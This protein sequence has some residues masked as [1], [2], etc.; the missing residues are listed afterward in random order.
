M[1]FTVPSKAFLS[2][3]SPLTLSYIRYDWNNFLKL[4]FPRHKLASDSEAHRYNR[5]TP[6]IY[7]K[8]GKSVAIARAGVWADM[9]LVENIDAFKRSI[10]CERNARNENRL[11][12]F[13]QPDLV[14][15]FLVAGT[16]IRHIV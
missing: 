2:V 12:W 5:T 4:K 9:A 10:M 14:N 3:N 7:P 6:I 13:M 11:D 15:Q 1:H 16:L 8:L